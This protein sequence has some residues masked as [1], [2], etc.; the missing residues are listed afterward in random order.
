MAG[1]NEVASKAGVSSEQVKAVTGAILALCKEGNDVQVIGFG[2]FSKKHKE[3]RNGRNP[4]TGADMVIP[5]KDVFHFKAA[6]TIDM[7]P[8]KPAGRRR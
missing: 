8:P 1:I 4:S 2:K 3:E 6:S 5:A 7:A